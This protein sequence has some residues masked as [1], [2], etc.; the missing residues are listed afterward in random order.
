MSR[1][2]KIVSGGQTGVDQAALRAAQD[3]GLSCGGWCPPGRISEVG[4]IPLRYPLQET[5][6]DQSP[7]ALDVPRSL[8][9]EWNVRDADATLILEP[10]QGRQDNGSEWT[11][12]C[13]G[14]FGRP[15]LVCDPADP[16]TLVKIQQWIKAEQVEILNVAGP[17]EGTVP[18]ISEMTYELLIE[19]FHNEA[20]EG[21]PS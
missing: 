2:K 12:S 14:R 21:R 13:A 8:R 11:K 15:L 4:I 9:S 10:R 3:C 16:A 19:L 6:V 17:S 5:P 7:D 1:L 18:G 20:S